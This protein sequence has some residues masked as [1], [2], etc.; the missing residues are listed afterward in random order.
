MISSAWVTSWLLSAH[1]VSAQINLRTHSRAL[2]VWC[3]GMVQLPK[4]PDINMEEPAESLIQVDR[5]LLTK[6]NNVSIKL[7]PQKTPTVIA[8][9]WVL[10]K[11]T[12]DNNFMQNPR[13]S[14]QQRHTSTKAYTTQNYQC[15]WWK[16]C[17]REVLFISQKLGISSHT[18]LCAPHCPQLEAVLVWSY[19]LSHTLSHT[20]TVSHTLTHT[21]RHKRGLWAFR[22]CIHRR[23]QLSGMH[24]NGAENEIRWRKT[25]LKM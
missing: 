12:K 11:I 2:N 20:H 8:Q 23:R 3:C 4:C 17:Y 22:S 19:R 25:C 18:P 7:W 24:A 16:P 10:K 5:V 9:W 21:Q 1:W 14:Y 6:D 15:C 13:P